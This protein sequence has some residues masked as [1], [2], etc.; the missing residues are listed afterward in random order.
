MLQDIRQNIQGTMAK[1]VIGL[2][3][4]SFAIFGIT[5]VLFGP[6][7]NA[8]AE[9]NG[10]EVSQFEL[11]QEVSLLQ[12]QLFSMLG[13]N[14]DPSQ[15]DSAVLTNQAI[16]SLVQ[17]RVSVQAAEELGLAVS[18]ET[19]GGVIGSME[20]FQISGQFSPELF[21]SRLATA[22]FTPSSFQDR[23]GEDILQSQLRA[24]LA[25]STFVTPSE[26]AAAARVSA[27]GR[28]V[29][30]ITLPIDR[31][32]QGAEISEE[33][34]AAYYDE[35]AERFT[36]EES[37][38]IEY[39]EV[40]L[41]DY[42][43]P[44]DEERLREEFDLVRDEFEQ[45]EESRVSHILFEGSDSER[46]ERLAAA[47]AAIANGMS[48]TDAAREYSDD[49][50]SADLG[51]DL[52]YTAGDAFPEEMEEAIAALDVGASGSVETDAGTHLLLVTDRR[53]GN[54]V[55]FEDV[56]MELEDR[57]QTADAA[58][59]LLIDIERLRDI[60]FN[61]ADLSEPAAALDAEVQRAE[62]VTQSYSEGLL[63]DPRLLQAA[64]SEDV[65]EQGH[66]SDVVELSP[67]QFVLL[68]VADRQPPQPLALEDVRSEIESELRD[69]AA[70]ADA[71][72]AAS[73]MLGRLELED[74]TVEALANEAGL[75]WQVELGARRDT[76]RLAPAL[77]ARL[78][79]L[80]APAGKE[81]VRDVV[82][83][84]DSLY[85][86][87]MMRVIP[88]TLDSLSPAEQLDLR[89]R[90]SAEGANLLLEQYEVALRSGADVVVY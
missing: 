64:F 37:V 83:G 65:L 66:N 49:V 58:A 13:E 77:K 42:V 68:R 24:G 63:A 18:D 57:I 51:G 20:E 62:G 5:D 46:A 61:A 74:V 82:E 52:G 4:I 19:L 11:Q 87:E 54:A 38:D 29:R 45:A 78:F 30:Y 84:R 32:R 39:F 72:A 10:Q 56:R 12:R 34:V 3:V 23:L 55:S 41:Q 47:E 33:A 59:E 28:D 75:D 6:Q 60:A 27:E 8:V 48:F 9:V 22:G 86:I 71:R 40:T 21:Q 43:E 90:L 69:S 44:V 26:L 35:N 50:G 25:G 88:G 79:E 85:L 89:Q 53:A 70:L 31:Y 7:S 73:G 16:Q 36:S 14:A 15:L 1:V 81:P 80:A 17:R 67:E 2:I 76:I